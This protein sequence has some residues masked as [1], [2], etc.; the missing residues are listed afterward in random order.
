LTILERVKQ[1]IFSLGEMRARCHRNC[2]VELLDGAAGSIRH[3]GLCHA[4]IL[5]C[6]SSHRSRMRWHAR[7]P[8]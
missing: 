6:N 5:A 1:F 8:L 4:R 2:D 3:Q 7:G